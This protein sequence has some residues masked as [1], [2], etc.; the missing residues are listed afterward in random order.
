MAMTTEEMVAL[1]RDEYNL[2]SQ[3][4]DSALNRGDF[5]H[6]AQSV[7]QQFHSC[8]MEGLICW[9]RNL[10]SPVQVLTQGVETLIKGYNQLSTTASDIRVLLDIPVEQATIIAYLLGMTVLELPIRLEDQEF[11]EKPLDG[12]LAKALFNGKWNEQERFSW[13]KAIARLE[14]TKRT[15]LAFDTY[16]LYERLL[17]SESSNIAE[18]ISTA[19]SLYSKRTKDSYFS[20]GESTFG[21]GPD[22]EY[23]VDFRLSAIMKKINYSRNSIHRWRW[24]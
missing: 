15:K 18:L 11:P 5:A 3:G 16:C 22:N 21:G 1:Y 23:V 9:R 13:L 8:Q 10:G 17:F 6:A 2:W 7:Y 12:L 14:R 24:D 19:E 20:E 4:G